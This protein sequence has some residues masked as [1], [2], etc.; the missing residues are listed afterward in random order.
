MSVCL[1]LS[2]CADTAGLGL[3][4]VSSAAE[5]SQCQTATRGHCGSAAPA[6]L[7]A[8][9]AAGG[10]AG[11]AAWGA[12]GRGRSAAETCL[13]NGLLP[14]PACCGAK[15][16]T[17]C[18]GSFPFHPVGSWRARNSVS[19]SSSAGESLNRV[20]IRLCGGKGIIES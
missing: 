11:R 6:E 12:A 14:G 16:C 20:E 8:R 13:C 17:A 9:G 1:L 10:A 4:A 7:C 3:G 18:A 19:G 15:C 2:L 5:V